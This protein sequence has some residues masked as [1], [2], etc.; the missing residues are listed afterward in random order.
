MKVVRMTRAP[1]LN[2]RPVI[3]A[4]VVASFLMLILGATYH[5]LAARLAAPADAA[6]ISPAALEQ[7]PLRI[8]MWTG[9]DV[10][11]DPNLV[12]LTDTDALLNRTYAR[13]GTAEHVSL[14]VACGVQVRDLMP[15]RPEVCYTGNGYTLIERQYVELP[16]ANEAELR[17]KVF[18]F[19]R[20]MLNK[21]RIIVL[22]YYIVDG[23]YCGDVSEWRYK[24][25]RRIGY[26][27]QVQITAPV[28][29]AVDTNAATR[30]ISEFAVE[31]ASSLARLFDNASGEPESDNCSTGNEHMREGGNRD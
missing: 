19:S 12:R 9:V 11:L 14:Y 20:G 7:F 8:G 2:L 10:P 21:N 3:V 28:T 24:A 17:C 23:Q 31:S 22:Y 18:Q 25:W 15:H 29:T 1:N 13:E 27:A 6:P 26:V 5:V 30:T 16:L 4:A